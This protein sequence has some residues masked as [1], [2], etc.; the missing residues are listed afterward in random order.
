MD[1]DPEIAVR[2]VWSGVDVVH[3][4]TRVRYPSAAEGGVSHYRGFRDTVLISLMHASLCALGL[5]NLSTR[6]FRR[7]LGS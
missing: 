1:F 3:V 6:P 5:W 4:P 2:L 7:G